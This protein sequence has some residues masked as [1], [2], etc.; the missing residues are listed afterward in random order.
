[1]LK[2]MFLMMALALFAGTS[3]S[4]QRMATVDINKILESQQDYLDAQKA[5]DDLAAK[6]R[7]EIEVDQDKIKGLYS[8]YQAEQVLMSDETRRQKEDEIVESEKRLRD[9]QKKKFGPDGELFQRRQSLV[10]PIQERVYGAIEDYANDRGF[11]FILDR[12]GNAGIIFSNDRYDK[13][14]DIIAKLR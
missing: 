11:D 4:A 14:D 13:T 12:A 7:R 6:W 3:V 5:L 2:N 10:Q 8:R 9:K 1:M